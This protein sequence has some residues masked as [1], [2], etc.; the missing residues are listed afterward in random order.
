VS[1]EAMLVLVVSMTASVSSLD[2]FFT[3]NT[4]VSLI[5]AAVKRQQIFS[6]IKVNTS[7]QEEK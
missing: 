6:L 2:F 4:L 7:Q 5:A 3:Y 1:A